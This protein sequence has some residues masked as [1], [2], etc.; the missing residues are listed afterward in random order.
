MTSRRWSLAACAA[1]LL[2]AGC[3]S[4][5]PVRFHSLLPPAAA[6]AP[7]APAGGALRVVVAPVTVPAAV[8]QPQW[9]VRRGDD[10]LQA[11][12]EDRWASPLRDELRAALRD[13]LAARW[14]VV[15]GQVAAAVG[16]PPAPPSWRVVVELLRL[17][18]RP[19]RDTLL[20]ARWQILP[21][22]AVAPLVCDFRVR[23]PVQGDG[24]V[25]LAEAHRRAVARLTDDIGRQLRALAGGASAVC[26]GAP[27]A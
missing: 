16:A 1:T 20:E 13:G 22:R 4:P 9:L 6:A 21:P 19:S 15:D 24:T 18:A 12:E 23:E 7:M 17:D 8:D 3:S 27:T 14:G 25:P 10:T 11:L 5:P 2:L 26:A